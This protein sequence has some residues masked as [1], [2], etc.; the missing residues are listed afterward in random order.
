MGRRINIFKLQLTKEFYPPECFYLETE[1]D[2]FWVCSNNK[3]NR[4]N[5]SEVLY[6][7]IQR[8]IF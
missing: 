2:V 6:E 8:T 7:V 1:F 3:V 4:K 5:F